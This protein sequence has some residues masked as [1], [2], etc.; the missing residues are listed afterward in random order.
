MINLII[1]GKLINLIDDKNNKSHVINPTINSK[2]INLTINDNVDMFKDLLDDLLV[3][4]LTADDKFP[5][6]LKRA[7][8][9]KVVDDINDKMDHRRVVWSRKQQCLVKECR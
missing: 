5:P 6:Y 4:N 3:I 7:C 8:L 2:L 9:D 1:N